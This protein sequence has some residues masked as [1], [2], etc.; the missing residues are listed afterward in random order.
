MPLC[1]QKAHPKANVA[2]TVVVFFM[3]R[4]DVRQPMAYLVLGIALWF[5]THASGIHATIAGVVMGLLIPANP[6]RD[7]RRFA[8]DVRHAV[9]HFEEQHS[10]GAMPVNQ[11][12]QEALHTIHK[13]VVEVDS[14]SHQLEH[15]LHPVVSYVILPIFAL[16]N[17]G[18]VVDPAAVGSAM[19]GVGGVGVALGLLIG[20]PVGILGASWLA[21]KSGVA[22]MPRGGKWGYLAGASVLGGI[23][24]TMSLFVTGLAFADPTAVADAKIG[25]LAASIVAA[26]VGMGILHVVLPKKGEIS[27]AADRSAAAGGH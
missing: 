16:A 8:L 10:P 1:T 26:A 4:R 7:R 12:Q 27:G 24:F 22:E 17:A 3:N 11:R 2:T 23:G 18:V 9:Q 25:I 19:T 6:R 5:A 21:V 13:A 15:A 20:K 14:P